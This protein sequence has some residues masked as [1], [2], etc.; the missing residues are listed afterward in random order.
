MCDWR[1]ERFKWA[2]QAL[3]MAADVQLR[4]F[5]DFVCKPEELALE[6][7]QYLR[8]LPKETLTESQRTA[9]R[10]LDD[11]LNDM[12]LGGPDYSDELWEDDSMLRTSPHWQS[13][14]GLAVQV[15]QAFAWPCEPPPENPGSRGLTYTSQP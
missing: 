14:R 15:L 10:T 8:S 5:P 1:T 11:K 12:S 4:L 7:D 13:V 2:T 3:A 9:V 6:W